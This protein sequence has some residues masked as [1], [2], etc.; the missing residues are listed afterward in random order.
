MAI[1]GMV[2]LPSGAALCFSD[3]L[4]NRTVHVRGAVVEA[5]AQIIPRAGGSV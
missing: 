2:I 4:L 1:A 3:A 5:E